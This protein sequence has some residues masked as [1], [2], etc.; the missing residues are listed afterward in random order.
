MSSEA[1]LQESF[2]VHWLEVPAG[3]AENPA[4]HFHVLDMH[5]GAAV[6]MR[7][8]LDGR[9]TRGSQLHGHINVL[10]A[11]STGRW[12]FETPV[13]AVLLRLA[14]T[15]L[16]EAADALGAKSRE[17]RLVPTF[18]MRDPHIEH[19]GWL[20]HQ[21]HLNGNP[22]GRL[23]F[24]NA[25]YTIANRLVRRSQAFKG[26]PVHGSKLPK[27]RLQ[28][29]YDYVEAQ[30]AEDL[31]LRELAAVA[32]FSVPHFKALFTQTTGL[33]A[34]RYVV[35]RRVERARQL[36]VRGAGSM[37]Q[38]AM[39]VGFSHHSHMTRCFHRVLGITPIQFVGLNRRARPRL[40]P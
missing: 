21:D 25:A 30:L 39:D 12:H 4:D 36:L 32:G 24:E 40:D 5:A 14:P 22:N 27:W 19:I 16:D 17:A 3:D 35:E 28:A 34:H 31:S 7:Y 6:R 33:P 37:A 9:E 18:H 29:V 20:I 13:N 15:L 38:I 8:R 23:W 10:P 11:G 2:A 26:S 1:A